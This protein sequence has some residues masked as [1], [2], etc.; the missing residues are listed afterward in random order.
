M[1]SLIIVALLALSVPALAQQ[2]PSQVD[3]VLMQQAIAALQAQRNRA[4]DE[5]A[6]AEAQLGKETAENADLKKQIEALKPK[7]P[8]EK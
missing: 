5:A 1:K 7:E 6:Q 8:V 2:P 4:L 3:P